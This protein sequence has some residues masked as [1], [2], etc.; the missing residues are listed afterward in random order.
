MLVVDVALP[1]VYT[2]C[3]GFLSSSQLP[4]KVCHRS[5][6][7]FYCDL[8]PRY[9]TTRILLHARRLLLD[10]QCTAYTSNNI[11]PPVQFLS[12]FW[13]VFGDRDWSTSRFSQDPLQQSCPCFPNPSLKSGS[14]PF[15]HVETPSL[16]ELLPCRAR[17]DLNY[18]FIIS[19]V[20]NSPSTCFR[21]GRP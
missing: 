6:F 8:C 2:C 12:P 7:L 1:I 21:L 9:R 15:H 11:Q 4:V 17:R 13:S 20:P 3:V 5:F 14:T 16:R 18:Q 10:A 19:G